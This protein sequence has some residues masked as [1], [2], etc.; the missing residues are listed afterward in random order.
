[1]RIVQ[2]Y[3]RVPHYPN[4]EAPN[5]KVESFY[6]RTP[7]PITESWNLV[8]QDTKALLGERL[9]ATASLNTTQHAL[10]ARAH[11]SGAPF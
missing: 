3:S 4:T 10:T 9:N 2:P 5:V 7:P 8:I 1:M 11:F 6:L